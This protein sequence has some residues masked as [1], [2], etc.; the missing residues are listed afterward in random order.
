[1]T[2]ALQQQ[3]AAIAANSTHQLDLK[4]QKTRH[5]KSLLFEARDAASQNFDTIYQICLEGFE[6]LCQLD[7]RFLPYRRN[8]FSEQSKNEDR[9][10]M[11]ANEN[12]ELDGVIERFLGLLGARLLLKPGMKAAEWLVRRFRAHEYNTEPLLLTFL[13]Y[14]TSQIF[15]TLLSILPETLP[16][17]FRFLHPYVA[18]LQSPPRYVIVSAAITSPTFF[19]AFSE[20]VLDV[21]K[22]HHHSALLLGF[23][24]SVTAQTVNGMMDA[25]RSG[26]EAVRQQKEEDVLLRVLPILQRALGIS[27]VPELFLGSCMIMTIL[28]TKASLNENVINA[29]MEAVASAWNEQTLEDGITCLAVLGEEKQQLSLSR[30][31]TRALIKQDKALAIIEKTGTTCRADRLLAGLAHGAIDAIARNADPKASQL[32]MDILESD[33]LSQGYTI[34]LLE[35]TMKAVADV[36]ATAGEDSGRSELLAVLGRFGSHE[37][38][39]RLIELAVKKSQVDLARLDASLALQL[40]AIDVEEANSD[41]EELA[42]LQADEASIATV[43][44][45]SHLPALPYKDA[46][47]LDP[48]NQDLFNGYMAAFDKAL[49]S[50][51]DLAALL[52]LHSLQRKHCSQQPGVLSFFTHVWTSGA[53]NSSRL[54]ALHITRELIEQI[55]KAESPIDMQALLPYLIAALADPVKSIRHAAASVCLALSDVYKIAHNKATDAKVW[56]RNSFLGKDSSKLT[57]L[58]LADA[59]KLLADVLVPILEDCVVNAGYVVQALADSINSTSTNAATPRKELKSS[60]R[61]G[62]YTFLASHMVVT[63]VLNV[64]LRIGSILCQIGKVAGTARNHIV[65]PYVQDH[66]SRP[67]SA[68][69]PNDSA[70]LSKTLVSCLTQRS[71]EEIQLLKT[72]ATGELGG[73]EQTIELGF[74]RLRQ[75]WPAM[76][77]ITRAEIVNWLLDLSLNVDSPEETQADAIETLRNLTLSSEIL[78]HL[79][80]SLPNIAELQGQPTPAKKQRTNRT[81]DATKVIAI[82]KE[83]LS[84][85]IRRI[86]LVLE[87]VEGSKPERHPQLLKGLFYILGELHQ[88]KTL[89]NSEL[90]YLQGLIINGLLDVVRGLES[91]ANKNVDR[92]VIRADLIVECVRT[93]SSTQV[94]HAALLLMSALASWAPDL[95]LHSVMPL[96]TFMSSTILKQGDDYSAHVTDQT[97]A[98]IIPPLAASL[99]KRGKDLISG[100]AELLLSFT[101]AFEHIPLHRRQALFQH[102]VATLGAEQSLFAVVAML[103]ERYPDQTNVLPFVSELM[104]NF[105]V[106]VQLHA[107]SQYLDLIV[108]TLKSK[109]GLSD[110]ILGYAEKNKD[111]AIAATSVLLSGLAETLSRDTLRKRLSKELKND[112]EEADNLRRTYSKLLE[113]SMQLGLQLR[114]DD[115][116]HHNANRVLSALLGLMPTKDFIDASAILMQSGSDEIRQQV[117]W[118]LEQRVKTAKRGDAALQTIFGETLTNCAIFVTPSQPVATRIAAITCIDNIS[119]K[120]GKTDR[121]AVMQAAQQIAGEA[122]LGHKESTLRRISLLCLASMVEVLQDEFIPVLPK[123]LDRTLQYLAEGLGDEARV[124]ESMLTACFSFAMA[125]LDHL[126]WMLSGKYLEQ[127]LVLAAKANS[128]KAK[129]FSELTAKKVAAHELL[130]AIERTLED[131]VALGKDAVGLHMETLHETIKIQTKSTIAKNA[132]LVFSILLSAFDIR[133]RLPPSEEEDSEVESSPYELVTAAAMEAVLKLN[134]ATLRPFFTRIVEWAGALPKKD[135]QGACCRSISLYSFALALF[136]QLKSL[137]TSYGSFIL[138]SAASQLPNL[139]ARGND[140]TSEQFELFDLVLQALTANFSNDQDGFWQAPAHFDAIAEPL[141]SQL[142]RPGS[143]VNHSEFLIPAIMELAAAAGSP[144]HH[145]AMNTMIM[146]YMRHEGA[147]VRLAA[148]KCERALTERLHVDWIGLLPEMLPFISEL[149]EDDDGEVEREVGRWILEIEGVTGES[150][151]SMLQ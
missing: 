19:A 6:E 80:E 142:K 5:S 20:Y 9:T 44:D 59:H 49:P 81:S 65:V 55:T 64:K 78:V 2:T 105:D 107:V 148:V 8:L 119:E 25:T 116:L 14:H 4:A 16:A 62:V 54:K 52:N 88:Y 32:L 41:V 125:I 58:P 22:S 72:L 17:N 47:F 48:D 13:P 34:L 151:D 63:P 150:L 21:A 93:T 89:L 33:L 56:S 42:L 139:L 97:V 10:R 15:P 110:V 92:S 77:D 43:L 109:R 40:D 129:Q 127:L 31:V 67:T 144:E 114:T 138:G 149:Q 143:V 69:F 101:A 83:K 130:S 45:L 29:M 140:S 122:A 50:D 36:D 46:S 66:F 145:K 95:V 3:L 99:K 117:F 38:G 94:H 51:K 90:V 60:S 7:N 136:D 57:W 28:A 26:R 141:I 108:D 134:D 100:A 71:A 18:S 24:A 53:N 1:M 84:S 106:A 103:V 75:L 86:T 35:A 39:T 132:Q 118:S 87:L 74:A 98:R 135:V 11:T 102:L 12:K 30:K 133:R 113:K 111:Q 124:D 23:W 61:T 137:V 126:P 115:I 76:K 68:T 131:V 146:S 123:T 112:E 96:F 104:G 79:V 91:T 27:D 37:G 120:F 121:T 128:Y 73:T 70:I 82:D 85:A 147:D